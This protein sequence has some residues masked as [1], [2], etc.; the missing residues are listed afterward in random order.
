MLFK[1]LILLL[2]LLQNYIVKYSNKTIDSIFRILNT[3]KDL[4]QIYKV[5]KTIKTLDKQTTIIAIY[6]LQICNTIL[7]LKKLVLN[8]TLDK[9][10]SYFSYYIPRC[11]EWLYSQQYPKI[12][13]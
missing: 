3:E 4:I 9:S 2:L 13:G 7:S 10:I 6:C 11:A 12:L 8:V 1:V 5:Q